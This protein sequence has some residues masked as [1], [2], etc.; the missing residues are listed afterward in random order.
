[1]TDSHRPRRWLMLIPI[2]IGVAILILLVR[3]R[4]TPEQAPPSE[5]SRAVRV[6]PVPLVDAVP[7]AVGYGNVTPGR[8]WESMAEVRGKVIER[9]PRLEAGNVMAAGSVLLRIDPTDYELAIARTEAEIQATRAQLEEL[10]L[11][12]ANFEASLAIEQQALTLSQAELKRKRDLIAKG[13]VS[14][15]SVDQEARSALGQRQKVQDLSNSIALL[16]ASRKLLEAQLARYQAQLQEAQRDLDRTTIRLPFDA[17]INAVHVEQGQPVQVGKLMIVADGI[18]T[19]EVEARAP[20]TRL[21]PLVPRMPHYKDRGLPSFNL[22]QVFGWRARVTIQGFDT[23]WR[24][25]VD[26][27]SPTLD[28]KT[29]TVGVLVVVDEPFRKARPGIK[30]PLF[31]GMF[32]TVELR[33]RPIKDALV[34]PR[35]ALHAATPNRGRVYVVGDDNRL[36]IH[37][38]VTSL[39]QPEFVVIR[40][41]LAEGDRVLVSD[42]SP[43]IEGML[44]EPVVDEAARERLIAA[45]EPSLEDFDDT[46]PPITPP[47]TPG[48]S[49]P[50][51]PDAARQPT[52]AAVETAR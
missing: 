44:L 18:A 41:G 48:S 24:A 25:R 9:N 10:D 21:R 22:E 46:A 6:L 50:A 13:T 52:D 38:V 3:G 20:I 29:R 8:V 19:A 33:G 34:V 11:K 36:R 30:P 17:R 32:V 42:L 7:R 35:L 1:M 4:G 37:E 12:A 28:P 23:S 47:A 2:V 49:P 14:R 40:D 27:I 43:A 51:I 39:V 15:S 31:N 45:A 5:R 26:R 16:P